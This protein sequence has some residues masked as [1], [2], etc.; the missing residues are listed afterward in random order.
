MRNR[1]IVALIEPFETSLSK[2]D[3]SAEVVVWLSWL[4]RSSKGKISHETV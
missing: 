4:Y 3:R 2:R 1:A